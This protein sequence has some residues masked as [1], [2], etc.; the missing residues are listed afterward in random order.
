MLEA[1]G[2]SNVMAD[3][4]TQAVQVSTEMLLARAPEVIIELHYG[5]GDRA[6]QPDMS[7][8]NALPSLPAVRGHRVFLLEGEEFVVPG[9][10]VAAA[11][12]RLSRTLH[13]EAWR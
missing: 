13:P 3:V 7:A 12:E 1:A 5:R 2:G 10:R 4:R 11:T 9:P 8:W 6:A